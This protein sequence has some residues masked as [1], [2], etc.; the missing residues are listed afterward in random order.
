MAGIQLI[1]HC[2]GFYMFAL[3][4][5][6]HFV[7]GHITSGF[8]LYVNI[9]IGATLNGPNKVAL[10]RSSVLEGVPLTDGS[11]VDFVRRHMGIAILFPL[12]TMLSSAFSTTIW[13][14]ICSVTLLCSKFC[15]NAIHFSRTTFL[16]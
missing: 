13:I 12:T 8:S 9:A 15:Y 4:R 1:M 7:M 2:V 11:S 14:V 10:F 5:I 3:P 6:Y 16:L